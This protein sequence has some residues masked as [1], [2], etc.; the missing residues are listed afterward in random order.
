MYIIIRQFIMVELVTNNW[1]LTIGM[2]VTSI[3]LI[4]I[5]KVNKKSWQWQ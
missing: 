3:P 4:P 1:I 2:C 5:E